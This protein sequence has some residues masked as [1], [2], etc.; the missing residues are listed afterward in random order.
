[1]QKSGTRNIDQS[2]IVLV[3]CWLAPVMWQYFSTI[4]PS[5]WSS[6]FCSES[7]TNNSFH[8]RRGPEVAAVSYEFTTKNGQTIN[9]TMYSLPVFTL[10]SFDSDHSK[11]SK[12]LVYYS[13]TDPNQNVAPSVGIEFCT[14]EFWNYAFT[15]LLLGLLKLIFTGMNQLSGEPQNYP[16]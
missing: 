10:W 12:F 16:K 7:S 4:P 9:H 2:F 5:G 13:P 3:I 11:N 15:V 14:I 6:A 8:S 1:M